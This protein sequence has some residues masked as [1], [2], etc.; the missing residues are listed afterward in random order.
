MK[1]IL[2]KNCHWHIIIVRFSFDCSPN[3]MVRNP[4]GHWE[5]FLMQG[6]TLT[7]LLFYFS[8]S[9]MAF[10]PP[11]TPATTPLPP[12]TTMSVQS[13]RGCPRLASSCGASAWAWAVATSDVTHLV[14]A[15]KQTWSLTL[16]IFL[17]TPNVVIFCKQNGAMTT[18]STIKSESS[19]TVR[20]RTA[21]W[22]AA[23]VWETAR[24]SSSV[25]HVRP[26]LITRKMLCDCLAMFRSHMWLLMCNPIQTDK[27]V[28][29]DDGKTY[30]VGNQWQKEY[31]G[32]ICTCTCFGGQQVWYFF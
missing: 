6:N 23:L 30:Q 13:G 22:W 24:E 10:L 4:S 14:S 27:S 11:V 29:Y 9:R 7:P 5:A 8:Q 19:G 1:L 20:Q 2:N 18:E 28:C 21:T 17:F 12:P 15:I 16:V 26:P 32:A 25:N 31:L 3:C